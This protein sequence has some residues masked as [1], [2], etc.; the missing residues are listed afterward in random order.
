[1]SHDALSRVV[2]GIGKLA[3]INPF[4]SRVFGTPAAV[5]T[6]LFDCGIAAPEAATRNIPTLIYG[7]APALSRFVRFA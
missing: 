1:M 2:R 7:S 5:T 4:P 3:L 6:A